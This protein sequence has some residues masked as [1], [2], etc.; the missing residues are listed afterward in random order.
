MTMTFIEQKKAMEAPAESRTIYT[1]ILNS[2]SPL[3]P[4]TINLCLNCSPPPYWYPEGA[5]PL[6]L[7]LTMLLGWRL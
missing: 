2:F 7:L 1:I 4:P 5:G 6:L 3:S